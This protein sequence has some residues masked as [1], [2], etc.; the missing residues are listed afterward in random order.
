VPRRWAWAWARGR[1]G[2]AWLPGCLGVDPTVGGGGE[3]QAVAIA[4]F[5]YADYTRTSLYPSIPVM[6]RSGLWIELDVAIGFLVGLG[7]GSLLGQRTV[8]VVLLIVFEIVLTPI[9]STARIAH[10][11]NFQRALVGLAEAH[12]EPS[13]LTFVFGGGGGPNG[14]Q[15]TSMLVPETRT[16]AVVVIVAWLVVWTVLGAWRMVKRDA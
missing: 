6:I 14:D 8:P 16:A 15:G 3:G 1:S 10:L 2:G 4:R 5:D 7:L 12:L 11:I 9:M 13:G